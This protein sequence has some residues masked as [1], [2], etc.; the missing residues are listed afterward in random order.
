M[1]E[2]SGSHNDADGV[3]GL[4]DEAVGESQP[5]IDNVFAVLADWRRR[6]VI[7]FFRETDA[8][9]ATVAELAIL[10]AG[11]R[12][13]EAAPAQSHGDLV[14]DMEQRHLPCLDAAGVVDFDQRS[15]TVR[16]RGAPTVEKWLEHVVAVDGRVD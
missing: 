1:T 7:Q 5:F 13:P 9:T 8:E 10:A 11:C 15:G 4:E 12:P 6:E 14:G 3:V 16:Y 2:E